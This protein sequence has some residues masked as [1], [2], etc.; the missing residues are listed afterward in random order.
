ME[1]CLLSEMS[2]AVREALVVVRLSM[3][4]LS[5]AVAVARLAMAVTVSA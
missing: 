4:A 5:E 3:V 2:A 1:S